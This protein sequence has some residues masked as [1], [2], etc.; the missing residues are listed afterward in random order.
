M[1][2][3][4]REFTV[5]C[6]TTGHMT[7]VK[8]YGGHVDACR[9]HRDRMIGLGYRFENP[10]GPSSYRVREWSPENER[11]IGDLLEIS[12]GSSDEPG[13]WLMKVIPT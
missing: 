7:V 11:S 12:L 4:P 3:A 5:Q 9:M 8:I 13:D 2:P 1:K 6:F 10:M